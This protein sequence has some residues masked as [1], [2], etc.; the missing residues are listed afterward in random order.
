MTNQE[1][2]ADKVAKL[3]R[4]AKS[5]NAHEAALAAARAQE[6]ID[7]Y[8]LTQEALEEHEQR[9]EEARAW[10]DP[11]F[12]AKKLWSWQTRLALV[13]AQHNQCQVITDR[14]GK[15]ERC[16]KIVGTATDVALVREMFRWCAQET[17]ALAH[18]NRGNGS[19]WLNNYRIGVT[20]GIAE[21]LE[22]Q[23]AA[24]F[25]QVRAEGSMALVCVERS[26]A[27][28]EQ[29]AL[30]TARAFKQA[31]PRTRTTN[32]SCRHDPSARSQGQAAGRSMN[33]AGKARRRIG[34]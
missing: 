7:R 21:Q 28:Q 11:L 15:N 25:A 2:I 19:V 3:L 17:D 31:Y 16:I 26:L 13:L 20:E 10:D 6:M 32:A 24:T 30:S 22:R 34:S 18:R 12:S 5:S 29:K 23:R 14:I 8:N 1:R 27:I 4:L 33:L 9:P